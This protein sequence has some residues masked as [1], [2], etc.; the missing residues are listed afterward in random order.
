MKLGWAV[1]IAGTGASVPDHV[2]TNDDFAQRLDT[3]DEWIVQR[4]GIRERRIVREGESTLTLATAASC[5][6]LENARLK[7]EQIDLILCATITPEH[8][9]PSTACPPLLNRPT[10]SSIQLRL[11]LDE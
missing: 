8:I 10:I 2:V 4:T 1:E 11:A 3:S 9:L 7:P 5:E 6:A